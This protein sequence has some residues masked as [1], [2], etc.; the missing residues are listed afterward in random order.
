M[1]VDYYMNEAIVEAKKALKLNEIP[2]GTVLVDN[3][4]EEIIFRDYN[5]MNISNNAIRH[6][7]INLILNA[8]EKLGQKYL[9]NTTLFVTLEPCCMCASAISEVHIN[10]VYFGAYDDKNGGI[11]NIRLTFARKNIFVPNIYGGIMEDKCGKLLKN[12]FVNY[13]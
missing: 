2:V 5:K 9:D 8:C 4:T 13:R 1:N 6:C 10:N 11:E 3:S 7:E 12:F